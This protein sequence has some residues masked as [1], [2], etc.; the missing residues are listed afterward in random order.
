ML[1]QLRRLRLAPREP[2]RVRF[3]PLERTAINGANHVSNSGRMIF[4]LKQVHSS[5]TPLN[6]S[7][8]SRHFPLEGK[9]AKFW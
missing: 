6:I 5:Q 9:S 4:H 3:L 2:L 7:S 8:I 1:N